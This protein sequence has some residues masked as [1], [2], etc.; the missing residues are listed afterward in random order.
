MDESG[1]GVLERA[2]RILSCFTEDDA[3][4][5]ASQL[6]RLTG[7]SSSTLHRILAQ[8]VDLGMLSRV[9]GRRYVVGSRLWELSELSPLSLRLRETALPYM[10]RIYEAT[11][12]NVHVGVLDAPTPR[13][14]AAVY[15]G[16][17]TGHSSIPTLSRMGGRLLPHA[18]G[19]GKAILALQSDDWIDEYCAQPLE[20]ETIH[21][22]TD[23]DAL[24]ADIELTRTRGYALARQEM[25]LGNVSIAAALGSI[26]GLPPVAMG[27]V[28]HIER[29]DERRLAG[30]VRQA[31]SDLTRA[32]NAQR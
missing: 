14:A 27:V 31:A 20:R 5:G 18:V 30:L 28:A 15:V 32:L 17:V 19:I 29:S 24:R 7:L 13:E 6:A 9:P 4:L 21:T 25:T 23:P 26:A 12:E 2:M 11:G 3:E 1:E 16:R 22:I 8:M 10:L